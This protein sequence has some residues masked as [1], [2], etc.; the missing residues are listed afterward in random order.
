MH[1]MPELDNPGFSGVYKIDSKTGDISIIE[2]EMKQPNGI[3]I[4]PDSD[5]EIFVSQNNTGTSHSHTGWRSIYRYNAL[6][7]D[8]QFRLNW[9]EKLNRGF[10]IEYESC[11]YLL[12]NRSSW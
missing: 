8:F 12:S 2:T 4:T 6:L 7:C 5:F 10:Y 1:E 11:Q 3:G 9:H